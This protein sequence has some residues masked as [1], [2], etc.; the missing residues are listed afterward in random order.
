MVEVQFD[1]LM[2]LC[3]FIEFCVAMCNCVLGG[4]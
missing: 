4:F 1:T 2:E 3:F